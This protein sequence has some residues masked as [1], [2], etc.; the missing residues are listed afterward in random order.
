[1]IHR[2]GIQSAPPR[3]P[4][5]SARAVPPPAL[6]AST[7]RVAI[8][9]ASTLFRSGLR[10]LLGTDREFAV[11]GEA[12]SSPVRDLVRSSAPH[13]LL[14]DAHLEDAL[15]VCSELRQKGVRP[16]VILA[17]CD[18]NEEALRALKCGARGILPKSATVEEL[19]KAVRVVHQGEV[20][21]IKHVLTLTVEELAARSAS[22]TQAESAIKSRLSQREQ[23]I[24]QLI[25]N[26]LSNLEVATRLKITEA[27][28]KAHLTHIFQKLTLRDRGQLA[29][30]Y[31]RSLSA[32][33]NTIDAKLG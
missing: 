28:V 8:L 12:N 29:A 15:A 25:A 17:G 27:T 5:V 4:F 21:A 10:S 23:G 31:H 1:M 9:S 32:R 13:I 18:S 20:W 14:L 2:K 19:I 30:L 6:A 11:V 22:T 24:A 3:T 33:H 16:W 7:I 26:G